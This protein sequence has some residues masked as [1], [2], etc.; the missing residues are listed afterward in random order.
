MLQKVLTKIF[1]VV[2]HSS[3]DQAA[4]RLAAQRLQTMGGVAY[5]R[6]AAVIRHIPGCTITVRPEGAGYVCAVHR[7]DDS[8][9]QIGKHLADIRF[10]SY[11]SPKI[12]WQ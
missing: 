3:E 10:E 12:K 9:K 8:P 6:D 1:P 4:V 7:Q 2:R 11:S 5:L